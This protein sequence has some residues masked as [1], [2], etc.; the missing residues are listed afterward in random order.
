MT[1][2]ID[3]FMVNL[4]FSKAEIRQAK[5][6]R[7]LYAGIGLMAGLALLGLAL[8]LGLKP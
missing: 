1:S 3:R 6:R 7:V 2:K 4:G 8:N 5:Y